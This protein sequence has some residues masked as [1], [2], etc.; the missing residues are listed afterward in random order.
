MT[1]HD[2]FKDTHGLR[3]VCIAQVVFEECCESGY[4]RQHSLID[5]LLTLEFAKD[6]YH[7][8]LFYCILILKRP[9][10]SL[11]DNDSRISRHIYLEP[12]AY[13]PPNGGICMTLHGSFKDYYY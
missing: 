13:Y 12:A 2:S 8:P 4:R 10:E 7:V 5:S 9:T 1:L 11:P 3:G 6:M